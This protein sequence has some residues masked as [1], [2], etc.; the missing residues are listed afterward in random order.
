MTDKDTIEL[1][2]YQGRRYQ[3]T[4]RVIPD[5]QNPAEFAIMVYYRDASKVK[6]VEIARVDTAHGSTHIHRLYRRDKKNEKVN[7]SFWE[8]V[9]KLTDRWR[10]YAESYENCWGP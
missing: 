9:S 7:W 6:N 2:R 8:A 4:Y 10:Q 1:G 5:A 3:L